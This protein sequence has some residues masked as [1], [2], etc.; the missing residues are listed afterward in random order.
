MRTAP[1]S[2]FSHFGIAR[3]SLLL[4]HVLCPL[5]PRPLH[6][7]LSEVSDGMFPLPPQVRIQGGPRGPGPPPDPRF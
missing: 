6:S 4:S 1:E 2:S 7:V 3:D 5:P